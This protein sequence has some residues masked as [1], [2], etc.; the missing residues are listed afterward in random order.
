MRKLGYRF[1]RHKDLGRGSNE[2]WKDS[3]IL[4]MPRSRHLD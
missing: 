2:Y 3:V 1:A 4:E